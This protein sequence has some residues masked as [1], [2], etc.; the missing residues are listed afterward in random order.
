MNERCR[1]AISYIN[2]SEGFTQRTLAYLKSERQRPKCTVR[3]VL[4]AGAAC[5]AVVV[6]VTSLMLHPTPNEPQQSAAAL[7]IQ[8]PSGPI[9]TEQKPVL[10]GSP[11]KLSELD[12]G[13]IWLPGDS[14]N[15]KSSLEVFNERML[16]DCVMVIKGTVEDT[17][18]KQYPDKA[19]TEVFRIRVDKVY[20]SLPNVKAGDIVTIEQRVYGGCCI[21]TYTLQEGRQY[22]IPIISSLD[23][24]RCFGEGEISVKKE[25]S[26]SILYPYM[27]VTMVTGCGGYMFSRFWDGLVNDVTAEVVVNVPHQGRSDYQELR[28]RTDDAFES[29]F[30]KIVIRY[31]GE[32]PKARMVLGDSPVQY[33]DLKLVRAGEVIVPEGVTFTGVLDVMAPGKFTEDLNECGLAVKATVLCHWSNSYDYSII[34][35]GV[36]EDSFKR[37]VNNT[38]HTIV[39]SLRIDKVYYAREGVDVREG[40]VIRVE[41]TLIGNYMDEAPFAGLKDGGQYILP[42]GT[43]GELWEATP[44]KNQSVTGNTALET[45]YYLWMRT[46]IPQIELTE[47]GGYVFFASSTQGWCEL[48]NDCTVDVMMD[49]K[50]NS[51]YK[52]SMK[53]RA[54]DAFEADFEALVDAY[55]E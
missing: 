29:D 24:M 8:Q 35:C 31:C 15:A 10:D 4:Y 28:F 43:D 41:N 38:A 16:E 11:V 40:D 36:P 50:K 54:D 14:A 27:P 17:R 25:S 34:D 33:S 46:D 37:N 39:Y 51:M 47:D 22:F 19:Q 13:D 20:Y 52:D 55:C 6:L 48:I 49:E 44:S 21:Q 9:T 5:I 3:K 32:K 53:L 30:Q 1:K 12:V 42:I 7:H 2:P 18:V 26:Y 45:N 23:V